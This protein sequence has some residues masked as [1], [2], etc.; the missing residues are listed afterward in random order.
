MSDM[1]SNV[2][3]RRAQILNASFKL[4]I[5]VYI[6]GCRIIKYQ[7]ASLSVF[8]KIHPN[9]YKLNLS[10]IWIEYTMSNTYFADNH[11]TFICVYSNYIR[12]TTIGPCCIE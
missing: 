11:R 5:P 10:N 3:A 12:E 6:S 8:N 1:A 7:C 9:I 4:D 2:I